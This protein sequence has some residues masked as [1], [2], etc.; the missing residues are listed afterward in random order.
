MLINIS[1]KNP[2]PLIGLVH[3]SIVDRGSNLLQIRPTTICNLNCP[4]CSTD[5]GNNSKHEKNEFIIELNYLIKWIREAIKLK[6]CNEIEANIDTVGEALTYT[7]L[8]GLIKELKKIP[9]IRKISMQSN[10]I[11]LTKEKI[12]ELE[13]A[14]L[15][16]INFSI[17]SL[18][19][20]LCKT[21]SGTKFYSIKKILESLNYLKDSKIETNLT[22][23]YLPNVNDAEIPKLI[24]LSK[25][26]NFKLMIQ[27]YE[28]FP[29]TRIMKKVKRLSWYKFYKKLEEWE[30]QYNIKL[31]YGPHDFDLKKAKRF[32]LLFERN[33]IIKAKII[34]EGR[35]K[36]QKIVAFK[37]RAITILDCNNKIGGNI[38]A[39]IIETKN[40]IYLAK[41]I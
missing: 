35:Y 36:N 31:K 25:E 5:A 19:E 4:F 13:K 32:P 29:H 12:S 27:K 1:K 20:E 39:K 23:V 3:I 21:L 18:D 17:H 30:K 37:N 2:I 15:N 9:E 10:G 11:L 22:P 26:L 14:G 24:K 38:K 41:K 6:E 28:I 33:E 7:H 16:K 34:S 8:K 40:S